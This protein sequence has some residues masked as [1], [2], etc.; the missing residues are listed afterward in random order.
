MTGYQDATPE[1]ELGKALYA[2]LLWVHSVLR[3]DLATVERLADQVASGLSAEDLA[4]ELETLKTT[5]PLWQ[6]KAGCLRY[7][8]FVHM[9]HGAE[10]VLLFPVIRDADPEL[11][12]VV[13]RLEADHRRVSEIL[14]VIEAAA[15]NLTE[16]GGDQAR[17]RVVYGLQQLHSHLLEHLDFEEEN[18]G[19]A[20]RRIT[21]WG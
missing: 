6:L 13:D 18:A 21:S 9:H 16:G 7:C 14:D 20:V 8:R 12:T 1:T 2:E 4:R 10:D 11:G 3:R 19:P 5:G 15:G 17:G